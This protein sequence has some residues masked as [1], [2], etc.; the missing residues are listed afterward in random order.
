MQVR[1]GYVANALR[2]ENCSPSRTITLAHL[3]KIGGSREQAGRL[4][5]IARENLRNTLRILK[6]NIYDGI[7]IYRLTSKL[8]P[9]CTHPAYLFWD[10]SAALKED[11]AEVG[12]F[13]RKQRLRVSLHPDHFTLLNSPHPAVNE[14]IC[15]IIC[16][17]WRGWDWEMKLKCRST[18]A[19]NTRIMKRRWAGSGK[20]SPP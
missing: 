10:W 12:A 5:T 4:E 2:F 20:V 8:V 17:F 7:H 14:A 15:I 11:L 3:K 9:F 18:S 6:G 19:V 1:L 16:G 13:V